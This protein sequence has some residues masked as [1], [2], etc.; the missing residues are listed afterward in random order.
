MRAKIKTIQEKALQEIAALQNL[1]DWQNTKARILGQKGSLTQILKTLGGLSPAERPALGRLVN[2]VKREI[3]RRLQDIQKT[4]E[5]TKRRQV[6]KEKAVDV[7]LPGLALPQGRRHPIRR[8][9]EEI[10]EIFLGM[11]FSI[12]EGPDVETDY[13]NF[14]A[15]NF[16]KE[17]PARDMQDT[18]YIGLRTL[19]QGSGQATD[20]GLRTKEKE[21]LLLRTHTSPVQIRVMEK[22]KPPLYM[23]APGTVYRHD[24]DVTHSP[25]FHQVEGLMVDTDIT[26]GDLKGVLHHFCAAVFGTDRE[27]R[28]RPS[29]FPFV[30]PGAEV[31]ISCALCKKRGCRVC[32]GSGWLEIL[33][34]GMVHPAVFEHVKIDPKRYS[35][36]AFGM[37]VERIAMLKYG[38]DD[39]RLFYE[40]DMRFLEQF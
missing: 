16:P 4:L 22:Q 38:I 21:Q 11:G 23:I 30:E 1:Q 27:V 26:L 13:Y 31:D 17:H 25:M 8:V 9:M 7:T 24:D 14:E 29:F 3:E 40:G 20:H 18:F 10:E 39:I 32:G 35:G 37:G 19:R 28:F 15:L 5:E 33:G 2:E 6:L 12:F 34:A 36:F